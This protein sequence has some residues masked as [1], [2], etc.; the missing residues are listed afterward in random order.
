MLG[1][2]LAPSCWSL[3][4]RY[5][6]ACQSLPSWVFGEPGKALQNTPGLAGEAT[7]KFLPDHIPPELL[8][9][10]LYSDKQTNLMIWLYFCLIFNC[11]FSSF[12]ETSSKGKVSS[13]ERCWSC[14]FSYS[15]KGSLESIGMVCCSLQEEVGV[16]LLAVP[17]IFPF[18][19]LLCLFGL[20]LAHCFVS[21]KQAHQKSFVLLWVVLSWFVGRSDEL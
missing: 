19:V 6:C 3:W 2:W 14:S 20:P 13:L 10:K 15:S 7:R 8:T 9:V 11:V 21:R 17:C 18:A 1:A 4:R 12:L 16:K 5:C